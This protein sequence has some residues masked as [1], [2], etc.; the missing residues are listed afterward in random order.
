MKCGKGASLQCML[1]TKPKCGDPSQHRERKSTAV[2]EKLDGDRPCRSKEHFVAGRAEII[3]S[4]SKV[5]GCKIR[6]PYIALRQNT[7]IIK[8][9]SSSKFG[10]ALQTK[11]I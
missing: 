8:K 9:G 5:A 6:G 4:N 10:C 2:K 11:K 1:K 7:S 3:F